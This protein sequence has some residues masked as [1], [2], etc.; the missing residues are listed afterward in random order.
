MISFTKNEIKFL[1]A[2]EECRV[3]TVHDNIP[4]VKPVSY[5]YETGQFFYSDRLRY[6]NV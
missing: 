5:L 4:H 2:M 3:A 1:E 6:A